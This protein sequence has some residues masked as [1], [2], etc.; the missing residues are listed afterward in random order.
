MLDTVPVKSP[1]TVEFF[2]RDGF[3]LHD[4]FLFIV[5]LV[6]RDKRAIIKWVAHGTAGKGIDQVNIFADFRRIN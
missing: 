5:Q 6:I 4:L 1:H 3:N 2:L